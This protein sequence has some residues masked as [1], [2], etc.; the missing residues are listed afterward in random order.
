MGMGNPRLWFLLQ[1]VLWLRAPLTSCPSLPSP[2]KALRIL[3]ELVT[4]TVTAGKALEMHEM[5]CEHPSVR[6]FSLQLPQAEP[7][8]AHSSHTG[9]T[10]A[11]GLLLPLS[12]ISCVICIMSSQGSL[13]TARGFTAEKNFFDIQEDQNQWELCSWVKEL[14]QHSPKGLSCHVSADPW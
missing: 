12:P 4:R 13:L 1:P 9:P 6:G 5:P 14:D 8:P 10:P 3:A 7:R 11:T 2:E